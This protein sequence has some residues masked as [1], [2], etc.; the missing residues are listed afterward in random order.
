MLRLR[1]LSFVILLTAGCALAQYAP[2][3]KPYPGTIRLAVD[4]TQAPQNIFR[5]SETIPVSPGAIA[6]LYPKWI[7]GEHG[8]TGPILDSTGL[9]FTA[10]GQT[11]PWRRDDSDMYTYHLTVP[12]GVNEIQATLEFDAPVSGEG[13]F[14]AGASSTA[15]LAVLSWNW[16]V[17]YPAG[18]T[19]EQIN[20]EP[21]LKIPTN[22]GFGTPLPKPNSTTRD[23]L[24]WVQFAPTTLYTLVDS[25]VI[26][27]EYYR[28]ID[29]SP[30]GEQRPTE[31]DIAADSAAAL[32]MPADTEQQ[33]RN[34]VVEAGALFGARHYRDYHFLLTLSDHVAHFGLEHHEANDSRTDERSLI[35]DTGRKLMS[36][37]LP[38]EYTHSWNGKY[39]RSVGLA[40]PDYQQPMKGELLWVYE[41]LTSYLGE[42]LTARSG[43]L[44]ADQSRDGLALIAAGMS[45]R[46]GRQWRPLLD[47]TVAAQILYQSPFQWSSWRRSVDFYDE[48]VMIW[49]D[50]DTTIRKLTNNQKSLDDWTR[51][52]HGQP[53]QPL[54]AAPRVKPYT[55]DELVSTMNQVVKYDW[56][57]FWNDRLNYVGP[58]SPLQGLGNS[59][60]KLVY[61]DQPS[62]MFRAREG[63]GDGADLAYSL[64]IVLNK[65]GRVQD[66]IFFMP[67]YNAGI[68]PGMTVVAV[69]GRKYSAD[70]MHDALKAAK[71][72]KEPVQ[73]L[74][75]NNDYFTTYSINYH[76][77]DKYP[78]LVRDESRPD[79]LTDIMKAHAPSASSK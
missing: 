58:D 41:G 23:R 55:F 50:A 73:L 74:V 24:G 8:P 45:H 71:N 30:A 31:L 33:Y 66:S 12:A 67:A 49:L 65:N 36:G 15:K 26:M 56:A 29:L 68:T 40:T 51:I 21:E 47:T 62:E 20:V 16:L 78:H 17:L 18:Y 32:D 34:L 59:G 22:W 2:A 61:D 6:L 7:P 64:G 14:S 27:G 5:A 25:P 76:E 70:V 35:E 57:K 19:A 9:K 79:L 48:G 39:R 1:H 53:D 44:N 75:E 77:G 42:V 13:G 54:N 10:N 52:F 3:S 60:W 63:R 38:H 37:L 46:P 11:I 72:S 43:L 4:A 28:K 69:N